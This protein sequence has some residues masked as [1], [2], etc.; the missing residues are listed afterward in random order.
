MARELL[1]SLARKFVPRPL[2]IA[3]LALHRYRDGPWEPVA[4]YA[5]RGR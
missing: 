3:G 4:S 1:V 5:F 2:K